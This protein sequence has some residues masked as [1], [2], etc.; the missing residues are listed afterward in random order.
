MLIRVSLAIA[1]GTLLEE[2]RY[3]HEIKY[4]NDFS[5]GH[6]QVMVEQRINSGV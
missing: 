6:F 3:E 5:T 2:F 1:S 4:E